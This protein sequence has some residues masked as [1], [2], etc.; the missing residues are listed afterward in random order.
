MMDW[1][2]DQAKTASPFVAAF[3]IFVAGVLWRQHVKDQRT[4]VSMGREM[5]RA[6]SA[7]SRN[8]GRLA[9]K[10]SNGRA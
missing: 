2:F 7:V 5:T 1:L 8:L 3:C 6:M 9:G 10:N 4:I